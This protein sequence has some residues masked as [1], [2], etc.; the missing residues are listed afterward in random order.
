[1]VDNFDH[2]IYEVCNFVYFCDD[3]FVGIH[4]ADDNYDAAD[5]DDA[6]THDNSD[7]DD[8]D[9]SH[10]I[11]FNYRNCLYIVVAGNWSQILG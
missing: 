8:A 9:D 3:S 4:H 1:M 2:D 7:A 11:A 6:D 10:I 5:A